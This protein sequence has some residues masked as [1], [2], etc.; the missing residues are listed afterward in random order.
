MTDA[1]SILGTVLQ[2][3]SRR[4]RIESLLG[5]GERGTV[6]FRARDLKSGAPASVRCPGVPD[7]LGDLDYDQALELFMA[8]AALLAEVSAAS[9]DV[10]QLL[11]YGVVEPDAVHGRLP[12]CVFEWLEGKSL[13]NH[14][15]QRAGR[16]PSIGEALAILEPAARGLTA[17]HHLGITHRNVRPKNLWLAG[18]DGRVRMKLTQF[19]LGSR[20]GPLDEAFSPEYG[21]PEQFKRSYGAV[22]P[23]T[24]VYGLA[25]CL[26]EL[27]SGRH[28]LEGVDHAELY[29]A[30]S[31]LARRPTLRARGVQVSDALENVV[32][33][34]LAVDPKRRWATARDFWD[35]LSSAVPELTPAV[36]SVHP[37]EVASVRPARD[38]EIVV[39]A[40]A[41]RLGDT[42]SLVPAPP[43][44]RDRVGLVAWGGVIA[45][46][47]CAIAVVSLA[48]RRPVV[49][50]VAEAGAT[51]RA[52][53]AAAPAPIA[54]RAPVTPPDMIRIFAG[55][56]TM[57]SDSDGK[58]DG[59]AHTVRLTRSFWI[60]RTETTVEM[61]AACISTGD[62]TPNRVHLGGTPDA[63]T[64]AQGCNVSPDHAAHPVSCVDRDQAERFCAHVQ[65]R[66]PTEAEWEYAARGSDGRTYPWGNTAPTSCAFASIAA[67][68]GECHERRGTAAAGAASEGKSPFGVVDMAGNV[69]EWV[70]DS[71]APY[72]SGEATDP[73]APPGTGRGVLRGGSWDFAPT[74]ARTTFRYPLAATTG[75]VST[76]F[77]C[78]RDAQD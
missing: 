68:A 2:R 33:R 57:G 25:L 32:A 75:N 77:R 56:F 47:A 12:Y 13:E 8:D 62:C 35:A 76:G 11:A 65:K 7:D 9:E 34:A 19:V 42:T 6:V 16:L 3:G 51:P 46:L 54:T 14:I 70:S 53:D 24:D 43:R 40:E 64:E 74:S 66:L 18:T 26:V 69:W 50:D 73:F 52:E 71:Y 60:D 41:A 4:F 1:R 78:A 44:P 27:V 37:P 39:Q 10:E 72:T 61:Y 17:A 45:A 31:E 21:A 38:A 55:V 5:P 63:A 58:G 23:H 15:V 30:T 49:T 67:L 48:L 22:G 28:A 36:P 29:L 59:P 20:V